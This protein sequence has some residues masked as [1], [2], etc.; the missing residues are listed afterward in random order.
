MSVACWWLRPEK[1][2]K[3]KGLVLACVD[4]V[5]CGLWGNSGEKVGEIVEFAVL[6]NRD[7]PLQ[8]DLVQT[9]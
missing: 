3:R 2:G 7:P 1:E 6:F 4:V 9:L 8:R 5:R